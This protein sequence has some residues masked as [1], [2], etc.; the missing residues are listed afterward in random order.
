MLCLRRDIFAL[1]DALLME[2]LL[3]HYAAEWGLS[4][5][6]NYSVALLVEAIPPRAV[7]SFLNIK[8]LMK[9][10]SANS[11][12]P[13]PVT[14]ADL[15]RMLYKMLLELVRCGAGSELVLQL[16]DQGAP[17]DLG[18]S[19]AWFPHTPLMM[20]AERNDST[21]VE[22][23]LRRGAPTET[24]SVKGSTALHLAAVNNSKDA[25]KVLVEVGKA[26][27]TALDGNGR[28]AGQLMVE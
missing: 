12:D 25:F 6:L 26:D 23:L 4:A 11:Q 22:L 14:D 8:A 3:S 15:D 18:C 13:L 27:V 1:D 5:A 16:L 2:V 28:S 7:R 21:T 20:A 10:W 24:R 19:S 9:V 17:L